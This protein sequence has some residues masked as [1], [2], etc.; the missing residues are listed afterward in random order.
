V[1][2]P[3]FNNRAKKDLQACAR[4]GLDLSKLIEAVVL[5]AAD[6][7]MPERYCDHA[8]TGKWKGFRDCHITPDWILIYRIDRANSALQLARIGTHNDIF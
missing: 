3:E 7:G 8:L 5:L 1:L 4:R 2:K 6:E